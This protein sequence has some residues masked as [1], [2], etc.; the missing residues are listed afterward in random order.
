MTKISPTCRPD[1]H[2]ICMAPVPEYLCIRLASRLP[3][4]PVNKAAARSVTVE[5]VVDDPPI[6]IVAPADQTPVL[7]DRIEQAIHAL[8]NHR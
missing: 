3:R 5:P 7:I 8:D 2:S 4:S 1:T 6:A